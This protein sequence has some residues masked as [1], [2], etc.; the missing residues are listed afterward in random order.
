VLTATSTAAPGQGRLVQ[1]GEMLTR[2]A[3]T[4]VTAAIVL[5]TFAFSLGT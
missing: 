5:M 2:R 4:V 1:P 3:V